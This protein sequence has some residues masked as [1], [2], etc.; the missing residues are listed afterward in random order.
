MICIFLALLFPVKAATALEDEL[1]VGIFPRRNVDKS[2]QMF[3]PLIEHLQKRLNRTVVL[4]I[5]PD[6]PAFW[7][8]LEEGKYDLVHLNQYH[9]VRAHAELGWQAILK[10][11]EFG[12]DSLAAALTSFLNYVNR[13][14]LFID[15]LYTIFTVSSLRC[16]LRKF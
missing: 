16:I 3:T 4:D 6:M 13:D 15:I 9:Y 2:F 14:D 1:R 12:K 5:P 10:N 11:E 8:R 7:S